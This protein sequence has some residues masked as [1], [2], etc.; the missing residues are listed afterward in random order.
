MLPVSMKCHLNKILHRSCCFKTTGAIGNSSLNLCQMPH[1]SM[2]A[3]S[4]HCFMPLILIENVIGVCYT[5]GFYKLRY[6]DLAGL[7]RGNCPL[8]YKVQA[9][10]LLIDNLWATFITCRLHSS[11]QCFLQDADVSLT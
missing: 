3:K 11:S 5:W 8:T 6:K 2:A 1:F 9:L 7:E 10:A 4:L